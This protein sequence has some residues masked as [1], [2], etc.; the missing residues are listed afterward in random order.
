[1]PLQARRPSIKQTLL[2]A[3]PYGIKLGINHN[4]STRS[5]GQRNSPACET[6]HYQPATMTARYSHF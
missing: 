1:M 5:D 3:Q 4:A 2:R 6:V